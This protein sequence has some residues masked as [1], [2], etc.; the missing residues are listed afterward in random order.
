[1]ALNRTFDKHGDVA[2]LCVFV[3][4]RLRHVNE[5]CWIVGHISNDNDTPYCTLA[6]GQCA[7]MCF[8][9]VALEGSKRRGWNVFSCILSKSLALAGFFRIA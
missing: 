4:V 6:V 3:V 2:C 9:G 5:A 1:M 7:F 8:G